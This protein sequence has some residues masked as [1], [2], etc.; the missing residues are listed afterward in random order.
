[1]KKWLLGFLWVGCVSGVTYYNTPGGGDCYNPCKTE[2]YN[3]MACCLMPCEFYFPPCD[4]PNGGDLN[5]KFTGNFGETIATN[6]DYVTFELN[7]RQFYTCYET[8]LDAKWHYFA[9]WKNAVNVG[10]G[11]RSFDCYCIVGGANLYYDYRRGPCHLD[12]HQ[13]SGGFEFF[14]PCFNFYINGYYPFQKKKHCCSETFCYDGGFFACCRENI[15]SFGGF[16]LEL[17]KTLFFWCKSRINVGLGA[18]FYDNTAQSQWFAG[19]R[20]RLVADLS[21]NVRVEVEGTYDRYFHTKVIGRI[22]IN[23]PFPTFG[24]ARKRSGCKESWCPPLPQRRNNLIVLRKQTCWDWNFNDKK[25]L[26]HFCHDDYIIE[27]SIVEND[28]LF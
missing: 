26:Q 19:G 6:K 17:D 23:I 18:Y 3:G 8:Y 14:H 12:F 25:G 9:N 2:N 10:I 28:G 16:D 21:T 13:I 5:F 4:R 20:A 24:C 22:S 7:A 11:V 15:C 27:D 1:M